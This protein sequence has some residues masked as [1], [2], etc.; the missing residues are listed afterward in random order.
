MNYK[1]VHQLI[2][3]SRSVLISAHVGP[4]LDAL[5]CELAMAQYLRSL[6]K[7]VH[8]INH[9]KAPAMYQFV[10]GT[11]C[12]KTPGKQ[13]VS[14]DVALIFDCGELKRIGKVEHLLDKQKP[15]VNFD[16]HIT[17][18]FFGQY[19]LVKPKASST[20][21]VLF[22]FFHALDIPLNKTIAELLYLGILTDTGSFRY[23]NT[24]PHTHRIAASLMDFGLSVDQIYQAVYTRF[25]PGDLRLFLKLASEFEL[26]FKKRVVCFSLSKEII[27]H[28][29]ERFDVR[30][31]LFTMF[32]AI[33][34]IEAIVI[35]TQV[36]PKSSKVNF[37]SNG[38]MNV[39]KIASFFGGGGHKAA[40][41]CQVI[42]NV[43]DVKQK[44]LKIIN[45]HL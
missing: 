2:K 3:K 39:A 1:A 20:A 35:F 43:K 10:K 26:F 30:D 42:G 33:R 40:S 13:A 9:E 19:N 12:I 27:N 29:G 36:G 7:R 28:I 45:K 31:Q 32:R 22:D 17:N 18:T 23:E 37:R 15:I 11:S 41:G 21:E 44:V 5:C 14:Y 4:D 38:R 25:S 24:A 16:H 8:I 6:K 34:G